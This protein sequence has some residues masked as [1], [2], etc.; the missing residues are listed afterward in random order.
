[1]E[2]LYKHQNEEDDVKLDIISQESQGR[3]AFH[4]ASHP[5]P[6]LKRMPS[7]VTPEI[8]FFS[9]CSILATAAKSLQ[10]YLT[11]CDPIDCSP[12]DSPVLGILQARTLEWVAISFSNA[13][14]WLATW[15]QFYRI[16]G[17]PPG[18]QPQSVDQTVMEPFLYAGDKRAFCWPFLIKQ[19][20]HFR[21]SW[22]CWVFFAL[23]SGRAESQW[24]TT[25]IFIVLLL[26][27]CFHS[28]PLFREAPLSAWIKDPGVIKVIK[29]HHLWSRI[30]C[31]AI[32]KK[33]LKLYWP[34]SPHL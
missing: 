24:E 23:S 2:E 12:P 27:V 9:P 10:S 28:P 20:D 7:K 14:K 32:M 13:W 34:Q 5:Y 33:I 21:V 26:F 15:P 4:A 3:A 17:Q 16:P 8:T 30:R 1:M 31:Y 6:H 19:C 11:L 25:K 18:H 22:F 29:D